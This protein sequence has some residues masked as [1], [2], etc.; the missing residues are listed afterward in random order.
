MEESMENSI[1]LC[2]VI[3]GLLEQDYV[4]LNKSLEGE[5]YDEYR[6]LLLDEIERVT[7]IKQ[8][9]KGVLF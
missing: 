7:V 9:L 1:R 2:D 6:L 5:I 8:K 4:K 3:V